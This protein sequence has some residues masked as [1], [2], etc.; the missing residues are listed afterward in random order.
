[1]AHEEEPSSSSQNSGEPSGLLQILFASAWA[2]LLFRSFSKSRTPTRKSADTAHSEDSTNNRT[3]NPSYDSLG[4]FSVTETDSPPTPPRNYPTKKPKRWWRRWKPYALL[5]NL[6]TFVAV[7]WYACITNRQW[8]EQAHAL[9]VSQ[10]AWLVPASAEIVELENNKDFRL[11]QT[12]FV[13][14]QTPARNVVIDGK[15]MAWREGETIPQ[16]KSFEEKPEKPKGI[17]VRSGG[18]Y[19]AVFHWDEVGPSM[20]IDR[21]TVEEIRSETLQVRLYGNVWYD[22]IFDHHHWVKFCSQYDW[23]EKAFLAC[24]GG[25]GMDEDQE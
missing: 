25:N 7:A 19:K 13:N 20:V 10:R 9:K 21:K 4:R 24:V 8:K 2:F 1:L 18:S 5:L 14:G 15:I 22:D 12:V 16:E 3:E 6:G 11:I 23:E 17:L